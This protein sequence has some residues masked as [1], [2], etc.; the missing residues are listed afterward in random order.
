MTTLSVFMKNFLAK[1][2][3]K[4]GRLV[5]NLENPA[6]QYCTKEVLQLTDADVSKRPYDN[7]EA[8]TKAHASNSFQAALTKLLRV[9]ASQS[10]ESVERIQ[11]R[12]AYS[13]DLRN[14]PDKLD[15]LVADADVKLWLEKVSQ[16]MPVYM[17]VAVHTVESATVGQDAQSSMRARAAAKVP[18]AEAASPGASTT[19]LGEALDVS[20]EA[21]Y[22][23]DDETSFSFVAPDERIIA[24]SYQKVLLKTFLGDSK[25][26]AMDKKTVWK[27]FSASRE[28]T[29]GVQMVG[30]SIGTTGT[31]DLPKK[32]AVEAQSLSGETMFVI[33]AE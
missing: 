30:A 14:V 9:F 4:P 22:E 31:N 8:L 26:P 1:D 12:K 16:R 20:A 13:Y 33:I 18:V 11:T 27:S 21:E 7:V 25:T 17:I 28:G 23:Q 3:A 2:D 29:A 24:V 19:P 5:T 32:L 15:Q 10:S 6:Y